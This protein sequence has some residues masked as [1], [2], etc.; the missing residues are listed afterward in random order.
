MLY[1][2]GEFVPQIAADVFIAP[3]ADVIGNVKIGAGSGIWFHCLVRG[4][5]DSITI[6]ERT[7][8]QDHS[9]IHVTGQ[10][11][12]TMIGNDCTLGHRVTVHGAVLKDHA[13]IGIGATVLDGCEVG[14][15]AM[16]AAGSLLPPGKS[17][18][19]GMLAMGTPAKVVR[20]ITEEERAMILRIP[21]T[22]ARLAREYRDV[23]HVRPV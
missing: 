20:P 6:G 19:D 5:V 18:P 21:E 14:E 3:S 13:F 10:K 15:F 4:D 17:I 8:I 9:I 7:N 23:T 1:R 12:A 11:Y 16:L 22:Y 2:Y